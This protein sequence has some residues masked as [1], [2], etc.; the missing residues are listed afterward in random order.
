[1]VVAFA[2]TLMLRDRTGI[3]LGPDHEQEQSAKHFVW[4]K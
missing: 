3:P 1:M 4:Q 2:A